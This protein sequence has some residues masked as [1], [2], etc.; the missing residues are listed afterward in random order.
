[1]AGT[2]PSPLDGRSPAGLATAEAHRRRAEDGPNELPRPRRRPMAL[3]FAAELVHFFALMLWVAA[4][5][6]WAAGLVQLTVA[7]GGVVVLNAVFSFIQEQRADRAAERLRVLLPSEVRVRRDGI[8]VA[9][10]AADVVVGDRLLLDAG[11]RIPADA[12][13]VEAET[14]LIDTS[15]LTGESV[16]SAAGV[17]EPIFAGTFVVEGEAE[18]VVTATGRRTRLA[19]I[20][21]MSTETP[22]STTPL[23]HELSRVVRTIAVISVSVGSV[24]LLL[25]WLLGDSLTDGLVF[26]IGVTVALVPEAL[27]PTVTLSLAWGA[28]Q[29]SHRNVLVRH[30]EAVETLGSTTFICTD[31][32]GTLTRNQMTVVAAWT[33]DGSVEVTGSG[34]GPEAR[35]AFEGADGRAAM[36]DLARV[37]VLASTGFA[38]RDDRGTGPARRTHG[39]GAR[40]VRP[41]GGRGHR[42]RSPDGHGAVRFPSMLTG[43][44]RAPWSVTR[45]WSRARPRTSCRCA[46]AAPGGTLASGRPH[47][48]RPARAGHRL[49]RMAAG[50][51]AFA[52]A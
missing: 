6:A 9:I 28:E 47:G 40:R 50:P 16:S 14:V 51:D 3:R 13:I 18:A 42:R 26:A 2:D 43:G 34:Y 17:S 23:T 30:L 11:D 46:G 41:T 1:M 8:A 21:T 24:F 37:G 7:I 4:A 29:M 52:V 25:S 44:P 39:R 10:D 15:M 38:A 31:K 35:V 20:A 19:A 27:L 33:P 45:P 5:L 22:R 36:L 48:S 49:S 12:T 32:T